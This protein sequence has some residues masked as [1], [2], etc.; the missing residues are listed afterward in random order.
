MAPRSTA[1]TDQGTAGLFAGP[2]DA[3]DHARGAVHFQLAGGIVIQKKQRLGAL[4]HQIVDAHRHQIL[5][6]PIEQTGI[7]GDLEL[8]A[9]AI[10]GCHQ[11]R[12]LETCGRQV[13]QPAE[14]AQIGVCAAAARGTGGGRNARHQRFTGVNIHAG[15]F[16]SEA[17]LVRHYVHERRVRPVYQTGGRAQASV[18]GQPR[19]ESRSA[20]LP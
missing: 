3:F 18:P 1:P 8:G 20:M 5:A 7:N 12:I 10:R 13:E 11:Y 14:A 9:D 4:H 6:Q 17:V 16:I 2:R 15:V 19:T